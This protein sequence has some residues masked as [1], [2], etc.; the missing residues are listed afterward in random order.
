MKPDAKDSSYPT[1]TTTADSQCQTLGTGSLIPGRRETIQCDK[2]LAPDSTLDGS[3]AHSGATTRY[4]TP[5]SAVTST[6]TAGTDDT[7]IYDTEVTWTDDLHNNKYVRVYSGTGAD[8]VMAI[9]GTVNAATDYITFADPGTGPVSGSLYEIGDA[10]LH[11]FECDSEMQ[12]R[13]WKFDEGW[14]FDRGLLFDDKLARRGTLCVAPQTSNATAPYTLEYCAT[15]IEG[16]TLTITPDDTQIVWRVRPFYQDRDSDPNQT[17]STW[18]LV[19][20]V[21][22]QIAFPDWTLRMASYHATNSLSSSDKVG[23]AE[24][25]LD[26]NNNLAVEDQDSETGLYIAEPARNGDY[27]VTGS[28]RLVRHTTDTHLSRFE[29]DTILM[30]DLKASGDTI[31]GSDVYKTEFYMPSLRLK[32][33]NANV[34]GA[35]LIRP[36][37]TF[38]CEKP[39]SW[40]TGLLTE[41]E[42]NASMLVIRTQN[43]NP[44]HAFRQQY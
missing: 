21:E 12:T 43:Q 8:N 25:T 38:T 11:Q 44:Y 42:K 9:T 4:P 22:K 36:D 27:S 40:P 33:A 15:M 7:H 32:S 2:G 28:F 17:P 23:F 24:F 41:P 20:N 39:A 19:Q 18:T 29:N 26:F 13:D 5:Q 10:W 30:A 37:Y 34:P 6:A 16:F 3:P 35:G 1:S 14:I 31:S